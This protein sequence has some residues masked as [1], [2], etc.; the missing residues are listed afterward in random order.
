MQ[1]MTRTVAC[2]AFAAVVAMAVPAFAQ[3]TS[4]PTKKDPV[5]Y[6]AFAIQMQGG[7]SGAVQI[8]IE[9]WTT[10]EERKALIGLVQVSSDSKADQQKLV[11]ALQDIKERVGYLRTPN[12]LGYDLKYAWEKTLA[13]G[14][15]QVVIA[16]DK[17]VSFL[18]A[19]RQTRT[20][21]YAFTLIE[22]RFPAG[23]GK[24]EGK[25]LGQSSLSVKDGKLEIEIYGQQPTRLNEIT[26]KLP[27]ESK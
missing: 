2:A 27:K 20:M 15:R 6:S 4:A 17:P 14:T 5:R 9:R 18:A 21:D 1:R 3:P 26:E 12:S 24:G 16:T 10:D 22:M 23:G 8:A 7:M 25:L 11:G 19:S 13:D